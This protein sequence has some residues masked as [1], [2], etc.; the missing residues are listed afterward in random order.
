MGHP[1]RGIKTPKRFLTTSSSDKENVPKKKQKGTNDV[2]SNENINDD[3][4]AIRNAITHYTDTIENNSTENVNTSNQVSLITKDRPVESLHSPTSLEHST[5]VGQQAFAQNTSGQWNNCGLT[6]TELLNAPYAELTNVTRNGSNLLTPQLPD[7]FFWVTSNYVHG[8][9]Y[10]TT[11]Y[12]NASNI[13]MSTA[14]CYV[15][16]V[17]RQYATPTIPSRPI[18][19]YDSNSINTLNVSRGNRN[20]ESKNNDMQYVFAVTLVLTI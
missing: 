19:N 15:Q 20:D 18:S 2:Q 9:E 4:T 17:S 8:P 1:S 13:F 12:E 6:Y 16:A 14:P 11:T 5:Y 7:S 10:T 3:I